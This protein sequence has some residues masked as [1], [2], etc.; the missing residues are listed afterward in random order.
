KA[1]AG[2][3]LITTKKGKTGKPTINFS[4]KLGVTESNN[5]RRGLGPEEYIRF[6]QDYFRQMFPD[7]DFHFYTHPDQLPAGMTIE[8]WRALSASPVDDDLQEWFGRLRL[9]PEEQANY[10]AG[11][12]MDMYDEVFRKGVIQEYDVSIVGGSEN[13]TYYWS[14]GYN[15]NE[16][17]RVGDQFSSIRS[18]LNVDFQVTEW[19]NVGMNTQFADRDESSVPASLSFYVNSPYGEMWDA[20][21]NLKRY[22]HG[23]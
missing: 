20:Q 6:R 22:P 3:V 17:I 11:R 14:I 9:F 21:G 4:T 7:I 10:R 16:G 2:V 13:V 12:T 18:R 8:E 15:N 5:Q 1:A 19:L 23:H